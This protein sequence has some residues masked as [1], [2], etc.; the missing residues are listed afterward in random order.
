M[1]IGYDEERIQFSRNSRH[2][3]PN[4]KYLIHTRTK[5][6]IPKIIIFLK[7]MSTRNMRRAEDIVEKNGN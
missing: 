4:A 1:A 5:F 2:I 3:I 6:Q 7:L